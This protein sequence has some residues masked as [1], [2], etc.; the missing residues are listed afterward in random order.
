MSTTFPNATQSFKTWEDLTSVQLNAYIQYLNYLNQGKWAEARNIFERGGLSP[1]MLPT[2]ADF[3]AMCDTILECKA[4]YEAEDT[5]AQGIQDFMGQFTYRGVWDFANISQYKKFS[6]VRYADSTDGS[7]LYI[8]NQDIT[9]TTNPYANSTGTSPQWLRIT[10]V[11]ISNS[12]TVFRGVYNSGTTYNAGDVVTYNNAFY[13]NI[14]SSTN[15]LPTT[16]TNWTLLLDTN[17]YVAIISPI[18][19]SGLQSG[20]IW[21]KSL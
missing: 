1:N 5:S 14:L 19:P 16:I 4:L 8:A 13:V 15:V 7:Y 10:P 9:T 6:I 18:Q 11:S 12:S 2:A 3:N 21:F 20:S 17:M